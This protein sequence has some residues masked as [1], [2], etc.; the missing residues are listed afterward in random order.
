[1]IQKVIILIEI[2]VLLQSAIFNFFKRQLG[3][4]SN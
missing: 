1:V 3:A 2:L 4:V